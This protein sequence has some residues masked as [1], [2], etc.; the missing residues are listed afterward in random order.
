NFAKIEQSNLLP[1]PVAVP[2]ADLDKPMIEVAAT[3]VEAIV[4][5]KKFL[6]LTV[7]PTATVAQLGTGDFKTRELS[8][9]EG[10]VMI[11]LVGATPNEPWLWL[12]K[13]QDFKLVTSDNK[14]VSPQGAWA[15][16]KQG[17]EDRMMGQYSAD[18]GVSKDA[19]SG[20][21]PQGQPS[22]V[23]I[24][25]IVPEGVKPKELQLDGQL[26]K[27]LDDE[28]MNKVQ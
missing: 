6:S 26:L 10:K 8:I 20:L 25:F 16:V 15:I 5:D 22:Q 12:T 14:S 24:A 13:V 17:A 28:P 7:K 2:S 1:T 3:G 19:L 21:S 9:P 11:Q 23:V 27:S 4:K 18:L